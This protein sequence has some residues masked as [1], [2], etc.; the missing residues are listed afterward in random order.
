MKPFWAFLTAFRERRNSESYASKF[1]EHGK[2]PLHYAAIT[3]QH[4][5]FRP[6]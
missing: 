5:N 3:I 2:T 4:D 1:D 6:C